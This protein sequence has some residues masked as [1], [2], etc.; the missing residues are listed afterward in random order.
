VDGVDDTAGSAALPVSAGS[1]PAPGEGQAALSVE[2]LAWEGPDRRATVPG[3][4]DVPVLRVEGFEGPLDWLLEQA[5][6]GRVD[7]ARLPVLALVEQCVAALEAALA[8]RRGEGR[9]DDTGPAAPVPVPLQRLAE[10]VIM[11][12]WLAELRSRLLLPEDDPEARAA[13]DEAEALRRQLADRARVRDAVTWLDAQAQLGRDVFARGGSGSSG[14]KA[15]RAA[16][17]PA[18]LRTYARLMGPMA[19]QEKDAVYRPHLH[20]LWRVPDARMEALL[21][22]LLGA[23][24]AGPEGGG[25]SLW[26]FLPGPEALEAAGLAADTVPDPA[27]LWRSAAAST[28]IAGLELAREGHLTLAQEELF[29]DVRIRGA[30]IGGEGI[31]GCGGASET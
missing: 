30:A 24:S 3:G 28:L 22:E 18:L 23:A 8:G 13:R 10:W 5:R 25:V 15:E 9:G 4:H 2:D 11:A 1:E 20:P 12:A 31:P 17:L 6:A 19:E 29:G 14:A 7:L 21:P 26:S 16:D 27:L